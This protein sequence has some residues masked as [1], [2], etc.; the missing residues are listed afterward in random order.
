MRQEK[1]QHIFDKQSKILKPPF[2]YYL[3]TNKVLFA[4]TKRSSL[5][6]CFS[7]TLRLND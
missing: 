2:K 3:K 4:D 6:G 7:R 1:S 5:E